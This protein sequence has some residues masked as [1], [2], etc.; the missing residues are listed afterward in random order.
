[1]CTMG[2]LLVDAHYT[3][4][5][6]PAFPAVNP[7]WP[8]MV[9]ICHYSDVMHSNNRHNCGITL[10]C[11]TTQWSIESAQGLKTNNIGFESAEQTLFNKPVKVPNAD[12]FRASELI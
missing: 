2:I 3:F 5:R 6:S 10:T 4:L 12:L 7:Q 11:I 8:I 9:S 1:M